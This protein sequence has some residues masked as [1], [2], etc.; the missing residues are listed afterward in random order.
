MLF[1]LLT[2]VQYRSWSDCVR[3]R[4]S[5]G[6]I[7]TTDTAATTTQYYDL[8]LIVSDSEDRRKSPLLM[9]DLVELF[10]HCAAGHIA[11]AAS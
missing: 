6:N 8:G 3:L 5:S 7:P 4:G 10:V 9:L 11:A 1:L 2:A